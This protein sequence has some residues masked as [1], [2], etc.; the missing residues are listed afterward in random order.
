[1]TKKTKKQTSKKQNSEK[2]TFPA[3]LLAPIG[4]FFIEEEQKIL[5]KINNL[6]EEDPFT[7]PAR[8]SN[9]ASP[10]ADAEEQFGHMKNKAI[11]NQLRRR[12]IQV[13]KALTQVKIGKYGACEKCDKLID[14]DRLM[15]Y[16]EATICLDCLKKEEKAKK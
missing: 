13:R 8:T 11:Q 6:K 12:L 15:I 14:T 4:R 10:D 9:N 1:M 2:L 7:D 16:P 5:K 3:D